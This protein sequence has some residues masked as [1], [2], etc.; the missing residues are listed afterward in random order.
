[1]KKLITKLQ[2]VTQTGTKKKRFNRWA[3]LF[4]VSTF[5]LVGI[6]WSLGGA[7][8]DLPAWIQAGG[9]ILAIIAS[10][11]IADW[12]RSSENRERRENVFA[13]VKAAHE[14]AGK[15]RKSVD[16]SVLSGQMVDPVISHLY[17][18]SI[19]D[20]FSRALANIPFHEVGTSE[21]I[22][23][24]LDMQIQFERFMPNSLEKFIAGP[25]NHPA[26]LEAKAQ[27]DVRNHPERYTKEKEL[28][29]ML[30]KR[31]ADNVR[32]NLTRI[33]DSF[34]CINEAMS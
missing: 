29:N 6:Y 9:S 19:T 4:I 2:Q 13:V 5:V 12:G 7:T 26:F 17:H 22:A 34:H 14:Y 30:F 28:H 23:A 3:C 27:L 25:Q 11:G 33:D 18:R 16:D 32:D 21:G 31:L 24:I 20:G 8:C 10:F 1:M 15:I